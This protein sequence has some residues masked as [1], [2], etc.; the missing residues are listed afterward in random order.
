MSFRSIF[1]PPLSVRDHKSN[2]EAIIINTTLWSIVALIILSELGNTLGGGTPLLVRV[3]NGIFFLITLGFISLMRRRQ[4]YKLVNIAYL[5]LGLLYISVAIFVLGSVRVPTTTA[6]I[7]PIILAGFLFGKRGSYGVTVA[8]GLLLMLLIHLENAGQMPSSVTE[9]GL[10]QWIS[11][12]AFFGI[13]SNLILV[14]T[15]VI[16]R[17][18]ERSEREVSRRKKTEEVLQLYSHAIQ[19]SPASIM[20]TDAQGKIERVNPK[21]EIITGYQEK[22]VL[23]KTPDFL[24]SDTHPATFYTKLWDTILAG[25]EWQGEMES[26]RKDGERYWEKI[27]IAPITNKNNEITHYVSVSEDITA[28][29]ESETKE[30][31]HTQRLQEQLQEINLLQEKLKRQAL[32]DSLTGLHN[33][34]YMEEVLLKE[35]ARAERGDYPISIILIDLD[36]LKDLN[37]VGGHATGDYALRSLATQLRA[38]TRKGDTI[39]RY[40][41]DEF[42]I[43]LPN[44]NAKDALARARELNQRMKALTLL[45]RG[46]NVL[47]ITFTAGIA[48]YPIHG[49]TSDEIFNF[50]DV[51]LYRAKLKG[52][53][54]VELFS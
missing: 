5:S 54:R 43:I 8:V 26:C 36:Y 28:R 50:A 27:S 17:Y 45:F 11:Y 44:T 20:I 53:N 40:G 2:Q 35:F 38:C 15:N 16:R 6:Y 31:E 30:K 37:D 21:F 51:A 14:S 48:T 23:G 24:R 1:A 9:P 22:E 4:P 34:H 52:R 19:H 7:L 49:K 12:T 33:R 47:R 42:A 25:E 41:G 13:I 39:C 46:D 32:R 29:R 10:T 3:F 18:L